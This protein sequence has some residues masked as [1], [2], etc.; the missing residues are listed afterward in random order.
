MS[1]YL[2]LAATAVALTPT[3]AHLPQQ[4]P[5]K[6]WL[7][8]V[9]D[10]SLPVRT[11]VSKAVARRL[12]IHLRFRHSSADSVIPTLPIRRRQ[13]LAIRTA[14][15]QAKGQTGQTNMPSRLAKARAL[16]LRI[17]AW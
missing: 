10:S 6:N 14:P 4:P 9:G 7:F 11:P 15:F 8:Q 16:N 5:S 3:P 1:R 2:K 17:L 13:N 12:F